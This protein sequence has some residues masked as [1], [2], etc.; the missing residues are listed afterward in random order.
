MLFRGYGRIVS[1]VLDPVDEEKFTRSRT[2][3]LADLK[4]PSQKVVGFFQEIDR[5][6]GSWAA[7]DVTVAVMC[8][9]CL[10]Y[11]SPSPRD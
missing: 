1:N 6:L 8:R 9:I 7:K 5:D 3:T 10:L 4:D 2:L 11:T